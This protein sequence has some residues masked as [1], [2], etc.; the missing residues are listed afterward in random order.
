MGR[1][2]PGTPAA[3]ATSPRPR[4]EV[5]EVFRLYGDA[6]RQAHRLPVSHHK[7]M[8]AIET[9][10]TAELGGHL[11]Q[12]NHCGHL[13]PAYNSCRN[14]HCPK[15]QSLVKAKWLEARQAELLPVHYF[16]AVFTLPHELNPLTLCNKA[17]V[18]RLLFRAVSQ[19]LLQFGRNNLGGQLGFTAVLHTWDQTLGDHFHLH[20]IIAGGALSEDEERWIPTRPNFLFPD[21]ALSRV[22]RAKFLDALQQ[23]FRDGELCFPGQTQP[24]AA[25]RN[26]A[27]LL[28]PLWKK[29]WVVRTKEPFAGPES[30]LDYLGRYTHR[31][32]ISNDRLLDIKDGR[33]FF[34]Y[35]NRRKED[36][37]E[38][39]SLEAEEFIRRFLLHVLPSGFQRIRHFGF[40]ANRHKKGKLGRCRALLG[41]APQLPKPTERTTEEWIRQLTGHDPTRCP[42]CEQGTMHRVFS[43]PAH[44]GSGAFLVLLFQAAQTQPPVWDSS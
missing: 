27:R 11:E 24:L 23:A 4:W 9:C 36:K 3:G 1:T 6:Y 14:R 40:L 30:V 5:A 18:F 16:H 29:D 35:K 15:C 13:R 17:V 34:R 8:Q 20:C 43:W 12:C 33:V 26:F 2:P 37:V 41:L 39:M 25:P 19:T 28:K 42:R 44:D 38:T 10:R 32:A 7:V 31:V 22:F 21:K